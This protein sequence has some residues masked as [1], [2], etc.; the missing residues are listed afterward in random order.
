MSRPCVLTPTPAER[1]IVFLASAANWDEMP[2]AVATQEAQDA[3]T[4][5]YG[6]SARLQKLLRSYEA[7]STSR[8]WLCCL[9]SIV[10]N[11]VNTSALNSLPVIEG[12]EGRDCTHEELVKLQLSKY[13]FTSTNGKLSLA[14][15][16]YVKAHPYN[17]PGYVEV[18]PKAGAA[19]PDGEIYYA[20]ERGGLGEK[21]TLHAALDVLARPNVVF[22]KAERREWAQ[23][24]G[25]CGVLFVNMTCPILRFGVMREYARMY[26]AAGVPLLLVYI[27]ETHPR[28]GFLPQANWFGRESAN[29]D[30]HRTAEDRA[31]CCALVRQQW[32]EQ[33]PELPPPNIVIDGVGDSLE[34]AY[35]ARPFR[36]YVI[37]VPKMTVAY[38]DHGARARA[39]A[40]L[41][42]CLN[43][44]LH[45]AHTPRNPHL[46][47]PHA[48]QHG[49]EARER[50][51][52]PRGPQRA[53]NCAR[54]GGAR[55]RAPRFGPGV[56]G[57]NQG[58][59][60][61]RQTVVNLHR[62]TAEGAAAPY[63]VCRSLAGPRR[64][65]RAGSS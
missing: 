8:R 47:R 12:T 28:D 9:Q 32:A 61:A 33:C 56:G 24:L 23:G 49:R 30:A 34:A 38:A 22:G 37:D 62:W 43:C 64:P 15:T 40:N 4:K 51:H 25:Q 35:E 31:A 14:G 46:H 16:A 60:L 65:C 39:A 10:T 59:G 6:F 5:E 48:S 11:T 45:R 13:G 53:E 55:G 27:R 3:C 18:F 42:P 54:Q 58:T 1:E 19:A 17:D 50:T 26:A 63:M 52:L 20:L 7:A 2:D 41:P 44:R 57:E 21:A 29:I 36:H